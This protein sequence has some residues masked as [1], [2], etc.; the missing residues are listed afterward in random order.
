MLHVVLLT[1]MSLTSTGESVEPFVARECGASVDA[2]APLQHTTMPLNGGSATSHHYKA[3]TTDGTYAVVCIVDASIDQGDPELLLDSFREGIIDHDPKNLVSER[4]I[5]LDSRPGRAIRAKG[6]AEEVQ[7]Y[8]Y[9]LR[10]EALIVSVTGT[11][12]QVESRSAEK[13][14]GSVKQAFR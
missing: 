13:Y 7:A 12:E 10:G 1:L 5:Q 3:R 6:G 14:L 4:A 11:K 9:L 8:L 2:P